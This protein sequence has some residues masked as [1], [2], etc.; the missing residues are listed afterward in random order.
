MDNKKEMFFH[1][2]IGSSRL[3]NFLT[4]IKLVLIII[5]LLIS[6]LR[7]QD[8][9]WSS[10]LTVNPHPSPFV[11]DWERDPSI[12]NLTLNYMGIAPVI[13]KFNLQI[14]TA[15]YGM[16]LEGESESFE[17][18]SGPTMRVFTLLDVIDWSNV[19]TNP[20]V[21]SIISQ[22]GK[23][24]EGVYELCVQ[25]HTEKGDLLT[26]VCINFEIIHPF[27]PQL[28]SPVDDGTVEI[29]LPTFLWN[30]VITPP[31]IQEVYQMKIVELLEGQT[32]FRAI[33]ANIPIHET[34]II[35]ANIYVYPIDAYPLERN[36]S[37]VWQIT[38]TDE[39]GFPLS[40]ND[41]ESEIWKF[42]Y[43]SPQADLDIESLMIVENTVYLIDIDLLDVTDNGAF[44]TFDGAGRIQFRFPDGSEQFANVFVENLMLQKDTYDNPLFLGGRISGILDEGLFP[45]SVT[46]NYFIPGD[47]EYLAP[48]AFTIGG[49]FRAANNPDIG[50]QGRLNF[51]EDGLSG[52]LTA[53]A[54]PG[55]P[56]FVL[57]DESIGLNISDIL[58]K[59]SDPRITLRGVV[60][61][62]GVEQNCEPVE[63]NLS[64]ND[65]Y[66]VQFACLPNSEIP[67]LEGSNLFNLNI[68]EIDGYMAGRL[69]AGS[70]DYEIYIDGGLTFQTDPANPFSADISLM[71]KPGNFS[72]EFFS[73]KG[74][75]SASYINLGWVKWFMDDME[76][77]MLSYNGGVWDFDLV[78]NVDLFF[79]DF[80]DEPLPRV[81]GISFTPEGFSFPKI[82]I[83]GNG[84]PIIDFEGFELELIKVKADPFVFDFRNW[85][86][87]TH[88]ELSFTWDLIFNMPNLPN[89]TD[90]RLIQPNLNL[91]ANIVNG[92]FNL[93]I[94]RTSF[95]NGANLFLPGGLYFSVQE[96]LGSLNTD[97]DGL[98]MN[99]LPGI[100]ISGAISLPDAF[101]C[102]NGSEPY[103]KISTAVNLAGNGL[104]TGGVE[105]VVPNCPLNIGI[106]SLQITNSN[107]EFKNE[108]GQKVFLNG[109]A[110]F[111]LNAP[112]NQTIAANVTIFYELINNQL[113]KL[114]GIIE[115]EFLWELVSPDPS[116]TFFI[117][118]AIIKDAQIIIDGRHNFVFGD[119]S[120]I[121]VT[122]D[123]LKISFEDFSITDGQ[124]IFDD[125]FNIAITGIEDFNLGFEAF[126]KKT[127]LG[128][129]SGLMLQLPETLILDTRGL[130]MKGAAGASL[131][132]MGHKLNGLTT[133]FKND[134]SFSLSPFNVTQGVCDLFFEGEKIAYLNS[135]GFFPDPSFFRDFEI[136]DRI[137]LPIEG[138]AYL[139]IKENNLL[140]INTRQI[141]NGMIFSTIEGQPIPLVFP[142]MQ[143]NRPLPPQL[144]TEFSL[145][146]N[147]IT[148]QFT[149]G[150][151][152]VTVPQEL[153]SDFDLSQFGI[154]FELHQIFFG[155][156][157]GSYQFRLTGITKLFDTEINCQGGTELI[158]TRDGRLEGNINCDLA[159]SIPLIPGSNKLMLN[160][161]RINGNF[162]VNLLVPNIDFNFELDSDL[163]LKLNEQ[164]NYSA[165]TLLGY[166]PDGLELRDY[167][168][169]TV[170]IGGYIDLGPLQLGIGDLAI[171]RIEWES[172]P[173]AGWDFEL[174]MDIEMFFPAFNLHLPELDDITLDKNG[175]HFQDDISIDLS[176]FNLGFDLLGFNMEPTFFRQPAF[177]LNWFNGGGN[178]DG[179][180][181]NFSFDFNV[182]L[183]NSNGD[184]VTFP[185]L[186]VG[187]TDGLLL[188]NVDF[189]LD[190]P[191]L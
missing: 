73:P 156:V 48:G 45:Q 41:G 191:G 108:N 5:T 87:G 23:L 28:I 157:E 158:L 16:V 63:I 122:F 165:W 138:L 27:P 84:I 74:D 160:F 26:E 40:T 141:E 100:Q 49:S 93:D 180:N 92:N 178:G 112:N 56:F 70:F 187:F 29:N 127:E 14:S 118:G 24:P 81:Q 78:M 143:F 133:K 153:Y 42:T 105:N 166:T 140:L 114:N 131:N 185:W 177:D 37:Y 161:N 168:L 10:F 85:I 96:F 89:G 145:T 181:W 8:P 82:S 163:I 101:I 11:S 170:G 31:T 94:P 117:N 13:F 51:D 18:L 69:N 102:E 95:N 44:L 91:T 125:I 184:D 183:P 32:K 62:F 173:G 144:L 98:V 66:K 50:L 4:N 77:N 59:F 113:I 189:P 53:I 21:E 20:V 190:P 15:E 97:F 55:Q 176:N 136:P 68:F 124:V 104:L 61:L 22:T 7:A 34:E 36:T 110:T 115:G 12:G 35:E 3:L 17:F 134:F 155:E 142:S 135:D 79:P 186:G 121:G 65:K 128:N 169:D 6:S 99:F 164:N 47:I 19:N 75:P 149:D 152:Q 106:F 2:L 167:R 174:S 147:T 109:A 86:P 146:I 151:L 130:W 139:Q 126:P 54:V 171:P 172:S 129:R 38:G 132:Y 182:T 159:Q 57:G 162:N 116:L 76:L 33:E 72:V 64:A 137:A 119:G 123:R 188:G 83:L 1:S 80:F 179:F 9:N 71:L 46:G 103:A 88:A 52:N 150:F 107:I 154:P 120:A 39:N 90:Q 148:G 58:I 67:L 60:S 30:Q 111:E 43:G 25:T 175:F